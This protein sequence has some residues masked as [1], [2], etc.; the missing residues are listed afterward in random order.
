[1][2]KNDSNNKAKENTNQEPDLRPNV[3]DGIQ[4][5]D[6][7]LPGWWVALFYFSIVFAVFYMVKTHLLDGN[8][9]VDELAADR[10][11]YSQQSKSSQNSSSGDDDPNAIL[12][13][14]TSIAEG[15]NLYE[16]NCVACHKADGGGLV[17]PNLTDR[18]WVNGGSPE[19]IV[20]SISEGIPEKGMIAWTPI[21]G[22]QKVYSLAA[23]VISLQGTNPKDA[24]DA[25]GEE[26][27]D[28]NE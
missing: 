27:I 5:Y 17:G 1:M 26:Y 4:E 20:A 18:F 21:L 13:S 22:K 9:I 7:K 6:N 11:D 12:S 3:I 28:G 25:Q 23:Y 2:S 24:M 8:L 15:K 10:S 14:E 16:T 19:S